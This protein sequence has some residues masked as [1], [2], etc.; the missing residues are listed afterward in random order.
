MLKEVTLVTAGMTGGGTERV[1]AVLSDYLIQKEYQVTIL[2]TAGSEIAYSIHPDVKVVALGGRT[3]GSIQKRLQRIVM[4]RKYM[5]SNPDSI[6]L[7]FG[8]ETNLFVIIAGLLRKNRLVISERNDPNQCEFRLLRNIVYRFADCYVFQTEEAKACFSRRIQKKSIVIPNPL[9]DQ[10]P[11]PYHGIREKT[12]VAVGRL[13]RQKNHMLLL[14]AFCEFGAKQDDYI[15]NLYGEGELLNEL[16]KKAQS[17][18][19][20]E[21]VF[22]KGFEANVLDKIKNAGMYVL[23]SDY[24]GISNSLMEAMAIGLPVISTDCPIGGSSML[25]RDGRNGLLVPLRDK[26]AL[27]MAMERIA[28]DTRLAQTMSEE[29]VSVR[30]LYSVEKICEQWIKILKNEE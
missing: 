14:E 6:M 25:V 12:I 3:G 24:E 7:S 10:I 18:G 13:N 19:I 9:T 16:K 27:S 29:A 8:T 15:L 17:L 23:S 26:Q 30:R 2:M 11:E 22:F 5:K 20:E 4:I 1:I 28:T 21:K